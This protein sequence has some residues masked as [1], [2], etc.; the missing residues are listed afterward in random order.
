MVADAPLRIFV[1]MPGTTMG[2]RARWT[3]ISEIK[4]QLFEPVALML[5]H[6]LGRAA[7]VVI[8]KDKT[9]TGGIHRSM[10]SEAVDAEVYIAD[11]TGAN[12]NVYLELGVRWAL[13]DRVTIPIAQDL[14]EVRFN[15]SAS[16]VI[17]YGP[18]PDEL[19]LAKEQIVAATLEGLGKD[20]KVDSPVRDSLSFVTITRAELDKLTNE[21]A[22][23]KAAQADDLVAA[24]FTVPSPEEAIS[25]LRQAV[26]KNPGNIDAHYELGVRLRK[27]ANYSAAAE[28]LR[29]AARLDERQAR[30]H[31]ELGVALSK[32]GELADAASAFERAVALDDRDSDTWAS[33]GG[34]RRRMARINGAFDTDLLHL[35][36]DAYHEAAEVRKNDTYSLMNE[37]RLG[38]LL[39]KDPAAHESALGAFRRLELLARYEVDASDRQDP[40]KLFDLTDAL[41]FTDRAEEALN[42]LREAIELIPEPQRRSYLTS[43]MEPLQ[44]FLA[45][46]TLTERVRSDVQKA[47]SLCEGAL[48]PDPGGPTVR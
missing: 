3:N 13:K 8:E 40:W 16:R 22:A 25:L 5:G 11:L 18:M 27:S 31:R 38:L 4:R 29:V 19:E 24:A 41:L 46:G 15:V 42:T 20:N 35:A 9:S 21:I 12:P 48:P 47:L 17:P 45:A 7:E 33:L 6:H 1:A 34:L 28:E 30:I 32:G 2:D 44:D 43:Y 26:L 39:A 14:S 23:L 36:H 37:A 10:F